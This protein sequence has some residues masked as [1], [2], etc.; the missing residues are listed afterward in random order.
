MNKKTLKFPE[1]FL[2]GSAQSA[3]QTEHNGYNENVPNT[4]FKHWYEVERDRFFDGKFTMNDWEHKYKDDLKI[5]NDLNINSMRISFNW[6][7]LMPSLDEVNQEGI[8]FY[9]DVFAEMRKNGIEK[10]FACINHSELPMWVQE[11]GPVHSKNYI[12]YFEK[13]YKLLFDNFSEDVDV[14]ATYN[15]STVYINGQYWYNQH[16][17]NEVNFK[18]GIRAMWHLNVTHHM[19]VREHRERGMKSEI[20]SIQV[21]LPFIPRSNNPDDIHAAKLAECF[22]WRGFVEP[23]FKGEM[24][25]LLME[26]LKKRNLLPEE[27]FLPEEIELVKNT[28]GGDYLGINYYRPGR[29]MAVPYHP[30]WDQKTILPNTHFYNDYNFPGKRMNPYRGWEIHPQSLHKLLM[31]IK[32]EFG[33]IKTYIT[34]NG[35]GV[36]NE[37]RYRNEAGEIQDDYRI[38]FFE[39]HLYWLHKAI[40]D[41]ANCHGF[42][43]WTYIDNWSWS[44]AYKNRYGFIE[45]DLDT[46]ERKYKKSA[47]WAKELFG[48]SELKLNK[49]YE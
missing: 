15:E 35:M 44:N 17:P 32:E 27:I 9:K 41:G 49:N 7:R 13:Y 47:Q 40:I 19:A 22:E 21:V 30:N 3:E 23:Q 25:K 45:L 18:D 10:I 29:A 31:V 28:D 11:N 1:G 2:W 39:E 4:T 26:E 38:D 8:N 43:M 24:P 6:A 37:N 5:A 42:H 14:W 46:G 20:G 16:W 48:T 33:N 36:E 12:Q 34:E